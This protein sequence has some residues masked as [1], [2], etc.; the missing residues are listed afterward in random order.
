MQISLYSQ[1]KKE[2]EK[3]D[4]N[5]KDIAGDAQNVNL[6]LSEYFDQTMIDQEDFMYFSLFSQY[7]GFFVYSTL[8]K[9][10]SISLEHSF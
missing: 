10:K 3:L 1:K 7:G 9:G 6:K 5:W 4:L 2:V 8:E